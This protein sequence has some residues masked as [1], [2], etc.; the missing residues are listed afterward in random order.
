ME[1]GEEGGGERKGRT[2]WRGEGGGVSG[3]P[4]KEVEMEDEEQGG[5]A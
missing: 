1:V 5:R 4:K 3:G 2:E